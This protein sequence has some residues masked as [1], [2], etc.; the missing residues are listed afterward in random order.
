MVKVESFNVLEGFRCSK[1]Y[2]WI[3]V[4]GDK[5]RFRITDYAIK[6]VEW[7]KAQAGGS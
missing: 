3:K 1:D 6:V 5:V 7:H 2:E 4:E